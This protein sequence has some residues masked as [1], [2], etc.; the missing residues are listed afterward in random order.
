[1]QDENPR[2]NS[3]S[4]SSGHIAAGF[5]HL[6]VKWNANNKGFLIFDALI[7]YFPNKKEG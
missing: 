3:P 5:L 4:T 6:Y 1:M 2:K 7:T